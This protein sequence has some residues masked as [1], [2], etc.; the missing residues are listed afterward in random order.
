MKTY[1]NTLIMIVGAKMGEV[2]EKKK[3]KSSKYRL[4]LVLKNKNRKKESTKTREILKTYTKIKVEKK[5]I[6][7]AV[8]VMFTI[9]MFI[10]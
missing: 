4:S 8:L 10:L 2:F 6:T 3:L 9:K 1:C 5:N 7:L